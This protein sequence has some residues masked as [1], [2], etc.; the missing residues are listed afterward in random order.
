MIRHRI[1]FCIFTLGL[2]FGHSLFDPNQY[3]YLRLNSDPEKMHVTA[4][5][6]CASF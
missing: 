1:V 2:V 6:L 5:T 3:D 4:A